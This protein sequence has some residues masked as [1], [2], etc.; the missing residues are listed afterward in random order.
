MNVKRSSCDSM[1]MKKCATVYAVPAKNRDPDNMT[2]EKLRKVLAPLKLKQ[3]KSMPRT[4]NDLLIRYW[5]WTHVQKRERRLI[6][7]EEQ[8]LNAGNSTDCADKFIS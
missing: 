8:N 4:Q 2:A 7:G 3:D 6:D 1:Y 5:R